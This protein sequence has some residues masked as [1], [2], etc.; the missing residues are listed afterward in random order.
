MTCQSN[1]LALL[2]YFHTHKTYHKQAAHKHETH[3]EVPPL[4]DVNIPHTDTQGHMLAPL[5]SKA[6][7]Q[8]QTT[9]P[10]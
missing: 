3:A 8:T 1:L 5:L 6:Y 2:L 7:T 9:W 10:L 4:T